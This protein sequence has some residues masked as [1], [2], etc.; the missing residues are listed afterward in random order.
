[1]CSARRGFHAVYRAVEV[2]F[3]GYPAAG[4]HLTTEKENVMSKVASHYKGN[5]LFETRVGNH[6]VLSDVPANPVWG[7]KDRAPTPPDYFIVSISSCV[8]AFVVQYCE[9]TGINVQDMSVEVTYEKAD[10]PVYLKNIV[11]TV[12]LP[13][14]E[15]GERLDALKKVCEHCTVHET[16]NQLDEVSIKIEDKELACA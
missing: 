8:A 14:A 16:I 7:G 13:Q 2:T 15:L 5:M 6:V 11:A 4:T 1:M 12:K 10:K 9:R 3:A